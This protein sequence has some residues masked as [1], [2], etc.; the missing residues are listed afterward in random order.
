ML[1]NAEC[2]LTAIEQPLM[3]GRDFFESLASAVSG[4]A[5]NF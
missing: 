2:H 3:G 4:Y 1:V 5:Q